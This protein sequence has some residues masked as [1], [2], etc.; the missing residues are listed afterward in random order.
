MRVATVRSGAPRSRAAGCLVR[1][2]LPQSPSTRAGG[3]RRP[4]PP[5]EGN[6]Q[7]RDTT[8]RRRKILIVAEQIPVREG[9]R[10][11]PRESARCGKALQAVLGTPPSTAP[12]EMLDAAAGARI[13]GAWAL[14]PTEKTPWGGVVELPGTAGMVPGPGHGSMLQPVRGPGR[15]GGCCAGSLTEG[16]QLSW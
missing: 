5:G 15:A 14:G 10:P 9:A 11:F 4:P 8:Q 2:Q 1:L 13:T 6:E 12:A 3:G 16:G 7:I